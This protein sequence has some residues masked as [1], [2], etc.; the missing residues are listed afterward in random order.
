MLI[1]IRKKYYYRPASNYHCSAAVKSGQAGE[2]GVTVEGSRRKAKSA[3]QRIR[4]AMRTHALL[5]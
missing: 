4:L 1:K 5:G 2:Y 3:R